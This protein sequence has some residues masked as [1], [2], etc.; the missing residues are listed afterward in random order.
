MR[1]EGRGVKSSGRRGEKLGGG[2][3]GGGHAH[4]CFCAAPPLLESASPVLCSCSLI[5]AYVVL[6]EVR[7]QEVS[8]QEVRIKEVRTEELR[9]QE[10]QY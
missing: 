3:S 1:G 8:I 10:V 6:Q 4:Y 9:M 2:V 5:A 7:I